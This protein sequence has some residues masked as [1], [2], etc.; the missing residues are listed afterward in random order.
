MSYAQTR[1]DPPLREERT[2]QLGQPEPLVEPRLK[3]PPPA[4]VPPAQT[5][6]SGDDVAI[7]AVI[8][9]RPS[10]CHSTYVLHVMK[11]S[12]PRALRRRVRFAS[13]HGALLIVYGSWLCVGEVDT[14][15]ASEFVWRDWGARQMEGARQG[16]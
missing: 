12:W 11:I 14:L 8:N 15:N 7:P 6:A 3:R 13:A 1:V 9:A 2:S 5:C 4:S 10:R 16:R